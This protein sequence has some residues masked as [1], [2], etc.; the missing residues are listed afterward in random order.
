MEDI[1]IAID[2][3]TALLESR[4]QGY[5]VVDASNFWERPAM[6]GVL[7]DV[8]EKLDEYDWLES[9]SREVLNRSCDQDSLSAGVSGFEANP[10]R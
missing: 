1:R 8:R 4:D 2:G 7:R 10:Y 9:R 5:S 3:E 6:S